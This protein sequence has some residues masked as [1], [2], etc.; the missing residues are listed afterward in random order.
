MYFYILFCQETLMEESAARMT[1]W[2]RDLNLEDASRIL[3]MLDYFRSTIPA[4]PVY[5]AP[6][7]FS[8]LWQVNLKFTTILN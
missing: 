6:F 8:V 5:T 3:E 7:D 2:A 4:E 1:A